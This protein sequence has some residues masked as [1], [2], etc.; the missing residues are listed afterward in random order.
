MKCPSCKQEAFEAVEVD[1]GLSASHCRACGGHWISG[2]Q[3]WNWL[4]SKGPNLPELPAAPGPAPQIVD[5]TTAKLCPSCGRWLFKYKVGHGLSF[6]IEHCGQCEGIWLD[7]DEWAALKGRNL[8]DD[9]QR[10]C[11][12]LWQGQVR[13]E[14]TEHLVEARFSR[15]LGGD[16]QK[17]K[18]VREWIAGHPSRATLIAYLIDHL[19]SVEERAPVRPR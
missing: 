4:R 12:S 13:R 1:Q 2:Q 15:V 14:E 7:K 10:I 8:H 3:Y 17:A 16:Y 11:D 18:Q 6:A 9:L 19:P 5:S